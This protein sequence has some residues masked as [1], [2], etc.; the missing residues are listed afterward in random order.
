MSMNHTASPKT[1]AL[2]NAFEL[3]PGSIHALGKN[4]G[5]FIGLLAASLGFVVLASIAILVLAVVVARPSSEGASILLWLLPVT[6]FALV[7]PYLLV[8]PF[9]S[10]LQLRSAEGVS[11]GFGALFKETRP[12]FW[13]LVGLRLLSFA[14]YTAGMLC[15]IVPFFFLWKRYMLARYYVVDQNMDIAQALKAS[16]ADAEAQSDAVWSLVGVRTL[17]WFVSQVTSL[18]GSV[19]EFLYS[20]APAIRYVQIQ[21][22]KKPRA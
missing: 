12:Y 5:T 3:F 22:A 14:I 11:V 21:T 15:F 19:I 18:M 9:F 4:V 7:V 13:R 10:Y 6:L 1:K 16:A 17:W 20:C 2:P 8:L